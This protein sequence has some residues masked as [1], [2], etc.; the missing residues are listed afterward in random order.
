MQETGIA[1]G[2]ETHVLD[3][4]LELLCLIELRAH[5]PGWWLAVLRVQ[6]RVAGLERVGPS[7][8]NRANTDVSRS[9]PAET[10]DG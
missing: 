2:N 7:N 4:L 6:G 10:S 8:P 1:L 9:G 3:E 5:P